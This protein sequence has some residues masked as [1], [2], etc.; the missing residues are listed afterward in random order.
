M[1]QFN[2]LTIKNARIVFFGSPEESV[3]VAD[4]IFQ[5]GCHV[6]AVVTKP[7]QP[8]GRKQILTPSPVANWASKHQIPILTFPVNAKQPWLFQDEVDV[9]KVILKYNPDLLVCA[10]FSLK[11][12]LPLLQHT[13]FG[14]LNIHPSLVPAY[15][16]PAPIQWQILNGETETGV[17][18]VKLS[19]AF[20]AGEIVAQE[21][22]PI[23]PTDTTLILLHRLFTKGADLL[24]K[25]LP[26]YFHNPQ[27][28]IAATAPASY[29]PRLT[30][31]DG[32]VPWAILSAA[33]GGN[34]LSKT[35]IEQFSHQTI[36]KMF[37]KQNQ[38]AIKPAQLVDR[39]FRALHPWPGLWTKIKLVVAGGQRVEKRLKIL[40]L[41]L[42][43]NLTIDALQLEGKKPILGKDGQRFLEQLMQSSEVEG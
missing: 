17:S 7:P 8:I 28:S 12:P 1:Q 43:A 14:G 26:D 11:I 15:R 35:T 40:N 32:F 27:M 36:G 31:D 23:H 24:L 29:F 9:E 18:I 13:K 42:T 38:S 41:H 3:I 19:E 16:G 21:K 4:K 6:A 20:D 2:N 25:I 5:G 10:D 34:P 39:A 33:I 37:C 22:E 30:R